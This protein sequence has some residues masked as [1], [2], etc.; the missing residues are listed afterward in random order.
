LRCITTTSKMYRYDQ[1]ESRG[2]I[3]LKEVIKI[4]VAYIKENKCFG[5]FG[6][7]LKIF[8]YLLEYKKLGFRA[9]PI[10]YRTF[11]AF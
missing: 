2:I 3:D 10:P 6:E 7:K 5:E 9:S 8:I 11:C 4:A 1:N